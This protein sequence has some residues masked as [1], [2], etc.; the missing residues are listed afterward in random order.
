[1]QRAG[2]RSPCWQPPARAAA[3]CDECGS[4]DLILAD[5]KFA[6]IQESADHLGTAEGVDLV[7]T[8]QHP[9]ELNHRD[10]G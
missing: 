10:P 4:E 6:R 2:R 1:M 9:V 5:T 7:G 3:A 8:S